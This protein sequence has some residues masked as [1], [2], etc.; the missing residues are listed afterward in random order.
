MCK[1][2]QELC[3]YSNKPK[4]CLEY[5]EKKD[6]DIYE[7]LS[8]I[9]LIVEARIDAMGKKKKKAGEA[10]DENEGQEGEGENQPEG[11][12]VEGETAE[13]KKEK[14][15]SFVEFIAY[16][17][18]QRSKSRRNQKNQQTRLSLQ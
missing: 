16:I 3:E 2:T 13:D 12:P 5:Y 18:R 6:K 9:F 4:K 17:R 1:L 11:K 14:K 8:R 15:V 10:Q 7:D